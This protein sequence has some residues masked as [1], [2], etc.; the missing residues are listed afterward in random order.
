MGWI[1]MDWDGLCSFQSLPRPRCWIQMGTVHRTRQQQQIRRAGSGHAHS[2]QAQVMPIPCRLRSCLFPA[3]SCHALGLYRVSPTPY[4]RCHCL[5]HS[6]VAIGCRCCHVWHRRLFVSTPA[7]GWPRGVWRGT[8]MAPRR[9]AR[10][11]DVPAACGAAHGWPRG[12]SRGT[13]M[14]PR[15]VAR[16]MDG[17]EA[18]GAAHGCPRGV[19][20]G[21]WMSSTTSGCCH[22]TEN[23][24]PIESLVCTH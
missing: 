12:V 24:G 16:H 3:G 14:S 15:R 4:N 7:H 23:R 10:H 20:R 19:W 8:W 22:S 9:V 11:M 18:C 5:F 21:T 2:L 17:P 13:W 6:A 1:G